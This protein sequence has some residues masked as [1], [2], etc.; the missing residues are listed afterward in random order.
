MH[1]LGALA[2]RPR[3]R[4]AARAGH[5][6]RASCAA[7]S[8]R[9]P[10]RRP[11]SRTASSG[12]V[13][14][15]PGADLPIMTA[16][17]AKMVLQIAAAYGETARCRAHQGARGRRRRRV[18]AARHRPAV[19]GVRSRLRLGD[20]GAAS[21]TPARWRWATRPSSTSRAAARF[22]RLA[23]KVEGRA[24]Q[25]AIEA[26]ASRV[27]ATASPPRSPFRRTATW[28]SRDVRSAAPPSSSPCRP[29]SSAAERAP[30]Q[31]G[32]GAQ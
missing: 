4:Q 21:A 17:Q 28:S 8:P 24:R 11:R 5:Q 10:S 3:Q 32:A 2:R 20:Q 13:M 27:Q 14:V 22:G 30:A 15:I 31:D 18:R 1:E 23:R 12:L 9:R 6:L 7:P 26:A 16:N 25:G 29:P 19:A